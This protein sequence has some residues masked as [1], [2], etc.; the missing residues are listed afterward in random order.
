MTNYITD[1]LRNNNHIGAENGIKVTN[2]LFAMGKNTSK[3]SARKITAEI[4]RYRVLWRENDGIENFIFSDT[5]HGYYLMNDIQEAK[6]FVK[7]QSSRAV[8]AFETAKYIRKYLKDKGRI[9]QGGLR[10]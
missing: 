2:M 9:K 5:E 8:K 10:G 6:R 4:R 7:S 3:N 1:F